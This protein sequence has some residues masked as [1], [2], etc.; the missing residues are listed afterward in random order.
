MYRYAFERIKKIIPKISETELIALRMGGVHLDGE[1]FSGKVNRKKLMQLRPVIDNRK[2]EI[3]I[4]KVDQMLKR[5]GDQSMYPHKDIEKNL[6][7]I[8]KQGF[9]GMNIDE[10][11]GGSKVSYSLQ[12]E[13]S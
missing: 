9:F 2:K 13:I 5:L 11:Y 3:W 10:K 1:I 12:S 7:L 6:S 4:T 8:G